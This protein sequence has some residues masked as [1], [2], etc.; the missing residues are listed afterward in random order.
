M[1]G[2]MR[3][4][5]LGCIAPSCVIGPGWKSAGEGNSAKV[6]FLFFK[7]HL[8][9]CLA[10]TMSINGGLEELTGK[11]SAWTNGEYLLNVAPDENRKDKNFRGICIIA[12]PADAIGSPRWKRMDSSN[13]CRT[14]SE[15][16]FFSTICFASQRRF[17]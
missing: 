14:V 16:Y 5:V 2:M 10:S 1:L 3:Q 12:K 4:K 15:T 11:L 7:L 17:E 8:S 13:L 9:Q 6:L